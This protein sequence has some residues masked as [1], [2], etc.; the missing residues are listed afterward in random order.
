MSS[1]R[2]T[3]AAAAAVAALLALAA[4]CGGDPD[5]A[6]GDGGAAS[7]PD[8]TTLAEEETG[9]ASG[10][11][12]EYGSEE[13]ESDL[14][15]RVAQTL[16]D[17]NAE[18]RDG[19]TV[20]TLPENV[21]FDFDEDTLL[22]EAEDTLD[23]LAEA[24]EYFADAPVRVEGH[25]DSS[26]SDAYNQDLSERRAQSVVDHLTGAGVTEDRITAE[27]FGASRPLADND[28]EEGRAQ[29]RRVD[30]VISGVSLND[31]AE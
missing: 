5:P 7:A 29:N 9:G 6:E 18:T 3:P 19:D 1:N 25:T 28:T 8:T 16:S 11:D 26:G 13:A 21:L 31:L 4:A 22:P 14:E 27:G 15:I 2:R 17:L 24:V 10:T 12:L 23:D 20:V 30:V